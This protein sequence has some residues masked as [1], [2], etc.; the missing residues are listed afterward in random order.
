MLPFV[1]VAAALAAPST[2]PVPGGVERSK[3]RMKLGRRGLFG[4]VEKVV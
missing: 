1:T 3:R 4:G 2:G